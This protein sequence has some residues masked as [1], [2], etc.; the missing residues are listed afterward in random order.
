MGQSD[1]LRLLAARGG[2]LLDD[3]ADGNNEIALKEADGTDMAITDEEGRQIDPRVPY[4]FIEGLLA[5]SYI[6]QG[7]DDARIYRLTADGLRA[8]KGLS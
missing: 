7:P 2:Y 1:I 6:A 3:I 8:G 4:D 5:Q